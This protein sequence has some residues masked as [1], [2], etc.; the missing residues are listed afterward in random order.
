MFSQKVA[1]RRFS[2][3]FVQKKSTRRHLDF[4]PQ[5]W[6]YYP[7]FY[8]FPKNMSIYFFKSFYR[9]KKYLFVD[10]CQIFEN[11]K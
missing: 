11:N 3:I 1:R 5:F 7:T 9:I 8:F 2:R 4:W 10:F 6:F